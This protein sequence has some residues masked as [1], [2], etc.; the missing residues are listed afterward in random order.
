VKPAYQPG[1]GVAFVR[2]ENTDAYLAAVVDLQLNRSSGSV[3]LRH[4]WV[5]HDCGLIV[6]P[7]GLRNQI[8][9]NVIQG[10]SRALLESIQWNAAGV[11]TVDW[12]TYPILTYNAVPDIDITLINRPDQ[13]ILGAGEP[14]TMVM[15]PAIG[16]AI[17][18]QSGAR[19][20][21]VPFT[22]AAVKAAIGQ[23]GE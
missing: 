20:R 19:L 15:A 1:R 17:F 12:L 8:E 4:V 3:T 6:N 13:P 9:G 14:T 21:R 5:A 23:R 16:S 18:A 7:D 11:T 10:S 2:Y 22:A